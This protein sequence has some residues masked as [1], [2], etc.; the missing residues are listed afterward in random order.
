MQAAWRD[1][2]LLALK[3]EHEDHKPKECEQPFVEI[4]SLLCPPKKNAAL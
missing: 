2:T 4:D 3:M 1:A